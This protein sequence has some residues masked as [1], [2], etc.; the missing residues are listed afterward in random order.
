M[1]SPVTYERKENIGIITVNNPPVNALSQAVRAGLSDCLKEALND[2]AA[3][4]VIVTGGGRTFMAGADIS[5]FGKPT[6]SPDL[7]SVIFEY[8]DSGK[9]TIAALHGT[10][11]GGGLEVS[12]G[13]HYRVANSKTL[14][15]LPE[16]KLGL[17]P[18]AGGTQ[19]LPRLV[20]PELALEMITSG[21]PIPANKAMKEGLVSEIYE[22]TT[23]E[24]LIDNAIV[25]ARKI[26]SNND[27]PKSRERSEKITNISPDIFDN[28]IKKITPRLRGREG[29]LR[30]IEAV[31]G[32]VDLSF[33]EGIKNE[34]D[35]FKL[36]HDSD[37]SEALIHSFFSERMA[38]KIPGMDKNT[39]L[40]PINKAVV[41]G[42]GTMGG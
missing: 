40:R 13:C 30:C 36:C 26:L 39:P 17:L 25:F 22:N 35:L 31:R 37:E 19:R 23:H 11:L 1:S 6:M 27:H 38:N 42:C 3:E 28:A 32:A 18:G 8:E 16:V 14:L 4:A 9:P 15:G 7:N 29:P 10:P 41:I 2:S 21:N 20:G 24:E 34:R 12:M 33:E 5:E